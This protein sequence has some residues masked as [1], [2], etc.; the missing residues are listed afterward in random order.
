MG[1]AFCTALKAPLIEEV[2]AVLQ[3]LKVIPANVLAT[4]STTP[5]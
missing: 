3:E 2:R 4:I 5:I 1:E